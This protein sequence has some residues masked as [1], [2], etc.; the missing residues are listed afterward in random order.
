MS[1]LLKL[2]GGLWTSQN[3]LYDYSNSLLSLYKI[4]VSRNVEGTL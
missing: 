4:E 2:T 1:D 3:I